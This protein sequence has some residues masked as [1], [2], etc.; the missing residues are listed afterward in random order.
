MLIYLH[1]SQCCYFLFRLLPF[2]DRAEGGTGVLTSFPSLCGSRRSQLLSPGARPESNGSG[3]SCALSDLVI[4]P[5]LE[6]LSIIP[7]SFYAAHDVLRGDIDFSS[8][9]TLKNTQI[10][11]RSSRSSNMAGFRIPKIARRRR[12]L[13]SMTHYPK[14]VKAAAGN[15]PR[16][17]PPSKA[18][19]SRRPRLLSTTPPTTPAQFDSPLATTIPRAPGDR[20]AR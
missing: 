3:P 2:V 4:F 13:L 14:K 6:K 16:P 15:A 18:A 10:T 1:I 12:S 20:R 8:S 9:T 17:R 19:A 11:K 5:K 7:S